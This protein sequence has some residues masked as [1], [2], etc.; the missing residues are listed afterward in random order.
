MMNLSKCP[1]YALLFLFILQLPSCST[2]GIQAV[3]KFENY[4]FNADTPL[5]GRI[6]TP[7][8]FVMAYLKKLDNRPDYV[9][10]SPTNEEMR[11]AGQ[12]LN[13]LPDLNKS[14]LAKH[15]IGVY[16]I[17]NFTGNGLCDWVVDRNGMVYVFIV[18][19][20]SAFKNNISDLLTEK[21]KTCFKKD[22]PGIDIRIN[23]GSKFNGFQYI[24]L[25]ESTHAVDYVMNITP[26][27]EV[28]YK[29]FKKIAGS[30]TEFTRGIWSGYDRHK[31]DYQFSGK[32]SFYG[33]APQNLPL[34]EAPAIYK[35]L[36][37]SPFVSLY[38]TLAWPEDLAELV[39]FYHLTHVLKQPFNISVY[40]KNK[41][42]ISLAP[43][44]F[45]GVRKRIPLLRRFYGH[46]EP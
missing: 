28:N 1:I 39:T 41:K 14:I 20:S 4:I 38:S 6:A 7:P 23:C 11:I 10:Y 19:N 18:F 2:S 3:N 15:L 37:R 30:D 36:S 42:I 27:V 21:E 12:S 22:T 5:V 43:M 45:A 9:P 31:A 24:L 17:N 32:V 26:Y 40:S 29:N 25:H 46:E 44:E 35:E 16:F 33:L 34:S 13:N 8:E